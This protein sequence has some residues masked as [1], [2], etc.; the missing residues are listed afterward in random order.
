M[1]G[2]QVPVGNLGCKWLKDF[3]AC[4]P[5]REGKRQQTLWTLEGF[6]YFQKCWVVSN[7]LGAGGWD[8]DSLPARNDC[9]EEP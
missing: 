6:L 5:G 4:S 8:S 3:S 1:R 7:P 2:A 9:M